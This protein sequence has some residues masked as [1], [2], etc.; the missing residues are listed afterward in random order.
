M[1][2]GKVTI[3]THTHENP[4]MIEVECKVEIKGGLYI[5]RPLH[6][7]SSGKYVEDEC[8]WNITAPN[9]FE[10]LRCGKI[11]LARKKAYQLLALNINWSDENSPS[12]FKNLKDEIL[13]IRR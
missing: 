11:S 13:K 8:S 6:K 5:H 9:G 1:K 4:I 2:N 10:I 7:C 3:A 12:Y